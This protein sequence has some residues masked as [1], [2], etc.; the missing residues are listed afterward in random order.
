MCMCNVHGFIDWLDLFLCYD[1][2][3]KVHQK[4][5]ICGFLTILPMQRF[6]VCA[7]YCTI[8]IRIKN[9]KKISLLVSCSIL[10]F[11]PDTIYDTHVNVCGTILIGT[12]WFPF[13][14]ATSAV[15]V[16]TTIDC[17]FRFFHC[18]FLRVCFIP[19]QFHI[20]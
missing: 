16:V 19:F 11:F 14:P 2:L 6:D 8:P 1:L 13:V 17:F 15:V 3:W 7:I 10:N 4:Q 5:I 18:S 12:I 9:T 20:K